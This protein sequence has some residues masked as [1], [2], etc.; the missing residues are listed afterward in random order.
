M[1][2]SVTLHF[3]KVQYLENL[4]ADMQKILGLYFGN[5]FWECIFGMY[6]AQMKKIPK[7]RFFEWS[8]P[9]REKKVV[10][11]LDVRHVSLSRPQ[12]L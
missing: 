8:F 9:L 2:W 10:P 5:V 1:M 6:S 3:F 12:R 7:Y 4:T 11:L